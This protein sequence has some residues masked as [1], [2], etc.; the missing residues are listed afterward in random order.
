[1][2]SLLLAGL[3]VFS[4]LQNTE[5][6]QCGS[7]QISYSDLAPGD[8]RALANVTFKVLELPTHDVSELRGFANAA[9]HLDNQTVPFGGP[10][11]NHR[12]DQKSSVNLQLSA[13]EH[14]IRISEM[15]SSHS[16]YF[17]QPFSVEFKEGKKAEAVLLGCPG[18][19]SVS[20]HAGTKTGEALYI[21]GEQFENW[22]T[23]RRLS[24]ETLSNGETIWSIRMGD[25]TMARGSQFKI[26]RGPWIESEEPISI[27][28]G[29]Q[30][31]S[32]ENE[33]VV[34]VDTSDFPSVRLHVF[35]NF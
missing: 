28:E 16:M 30:W 20:V 23:A 17:S 19:F 18:P 15:T 27:H 24:T 11:T 29:L 33:K 31:Q 21:A 9:V 25:D 2:H 13:G 34:N 8:N 3:T 14:V 22:T 5:A 32:G 1:M 7:T 6:L 4:P 35:P 10:M 12:L 26:L